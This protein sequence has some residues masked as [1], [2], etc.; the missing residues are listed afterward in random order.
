MP[1]IVKDAATSG[2]PVTSGN[3]NGAVLQ[4]PA[5][6]RP[7]AEIGGRVQPVAL[8]VPVSLNGSRTLEGS[9]QREPFSEATKTVLVF[10]NGAVIRLIAAVAPGQLLFL[11]NEKT[12]REVVCQVVKSK[13]YRNVSGYVELE[14]T[15]SAVGFW[16][17]RFPTDRLGPAKETSPAAVSPSA[18]PLR[19]EIKRE[20]R[21]PLS[22]D[23][24]A[25]SPPDHI[26]EASKHDY[27]FDSFPF[28]PPTAAP[29][30]PAV[31]KA[32]GPAAP[33]AHEAAKSLDELLAEFTVKPPASEELTSLQ[34][35]LET[36]RLQEQL[37]S[38]FFAAD[39]SAGVSDAGTTSAVPANQ[40][41]AEKVFDVINAPVSQPETKI[42]GLPQSS[43]LHL[44]EAQSDESE[45]PAWLKFTPAPSALNSESAAKAESSTEADEEPEVSGESQNLA[46]P[47]FGNTLT[48]GLSKETQSTGSKKGLWLG[49]AAA[50]VVLL[51]GGFWYLQQSGFITSVIASRSGTSPA[52]TSSGAGEDV[53]KPATQAAPVAS[54][55]VPNSVKTNSA[56]SAPATTLP[57]TGPLSVPANSSAIST[58][59]EPPAAQ[60]KK[61][62]F[63]KL[64]LAAP[65]FHAKSSSQDGGVAAPNF[66]AQNL[67][68]AAAMSTNFGV[69]TGQPAAP[70]SPLAVGGNVIPAKLL[71][72][73]QPVYSALAKS[74]HISGDV[75][76]DALI[77]ANGRVTTTK[78]LSGPTL[79]QQSAMDALRQWKYKPATLNGSPVSMHLT[80]TLQFRL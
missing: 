36:T 45:M 38:S 12:K 71:S 65:V 29:K 32:S 78:V 6:Y 41:L 15:E 53:A 9:D 37:S 57:S 76:I 18:S 39:Q 72:S 43:P 40:H 79:L 5:A 20:E 22:Q 19:P 62:A 26:L 50:A 35:K 58:S 4:M 63:G 16:G 42:Q 21:A 64:H 2:S 59:N 54:A 44:S 28:A 75:K 73:V 25:A 68:S 77:D 10:A 49:L 66:D 7:V 31:D 47:N 67:P 23:I 17:V 24:P 46:V 33:P 13:T 80:V 51:G 1:P 48:A 56:G 52:N 8:E 70:S 14:F 27:S 30:I 55:A 11:T 34:L 69:S 74:Q 60:S 3:E 61:P